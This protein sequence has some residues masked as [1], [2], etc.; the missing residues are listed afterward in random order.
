M[1]GKSCAKFLRSLF[2]IFS[3]SQILIFSLSSC[4]PSGDTFVMKGKFKNFSQGE[5][6][7]YSLEGKGRIDTIRLADGKFDYEIPLEDT[8]AFLMIFPNYSE[9]PFIAS[10]GTLLKMV[11]DASHLR[12]VAVTGNKDNE[13][14][15]QFRLEIAE[16]T[17]PEALKA[18]AAFIKENPASPACMYVLN[19]FFL[20][21]AD[22]DFKQAN[23]LVSLMAKAVP[24]NLRYQELQRQV[25]TLNATRLNERILP[26]T[27]TTINGRHISNTTLQG[28]LNIILTW[29][30]WNYESQNIQ[31]RLHELVKN[32]GNR[33][34]LLSLCLDGNPA[35]CKQSLSR[36]SV[37]FP[38]VCD[39]K[40]WQSPLVANFGIYAVPFI[41]L[42]DRHGRILSRGITYEEVKREADELRF[43]K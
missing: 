7:V 26:F 39:G 2:L 33:L 16:Q 36:D 3:F 42:T 11:G 13:L 9:I 37:S 1:T 8:V 43:R 28:D 41:M 35:D 24:A 19:R 29:A 17:P 30:S 40:M 6:Y 18:A 22:A 21:R 12:E 14:L 10:P 34:T 25:A 38:V 4:N 31:R 23:E 27:A 20:A 32:S 5:L 15:T